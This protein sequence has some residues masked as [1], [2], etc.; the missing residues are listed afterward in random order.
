MKIIFWQKED[1]FE[2]KRYFGNKDFWEKMNNLLKIEFMV[3][4]SSVKY[5]KKQRLRVGV[6]ARNYFR[7]DMKAKYVREDFL[8]CFR[9]YC[10]QM[11]PDECLMLLPYCSIHIQLQDSNPVFAGVHMCILP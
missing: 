8:D 11:L 1:F 4:K 3:E 2:M 9:C 6:S 10:I 5:K 7:N